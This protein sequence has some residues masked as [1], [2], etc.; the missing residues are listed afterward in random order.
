MHVQLDDL[1]AEA[2]ERVRPV[3]FVCLHT[4]PGN[5]QAWV[6][7]RGNDDPDFARQLRKGAGADPTASGATRVAGHPNFKDKYAPNFPVVE[8]THLVP[9]RF[10]TSGELEGQGLIAPTEELIPVPARVSLTYAGP[11]K[12]PSYQRCVDNAPPND[13]N[14]GPDISRADFVWC[15]TAIDW[16]WGIKEVAE[17]LM[18]LSM[19][20]REEGEGYALRTAR[21][22]AAAI[23]R[24]KGLGI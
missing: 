4:S 16:G 18:K 3:A 12:L 21:S 7:V 10:V 17:R 9:G 23:Q 13:S 22:A 20:A 8:I 14:T 5:Y 2:I 24:R 11:R 15:M 19:K 1:D 6:A